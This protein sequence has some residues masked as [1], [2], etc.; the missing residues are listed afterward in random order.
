MQDACNACYNAASKLFPKAKVLMCYYHVMANIKKHKNKL[1]NEDD[2]KKY[3]AKYKDFMNDIMQI[4]YSTTEKEYKERLANFKNEW[5]DREPEMFKYVNEQWLQGFFNNWKIFRNDPGYANTNS[6]IESFN[7][8]FKRDYTKH[9]KCSIITICNKIFECIVEYSTSPENVFY[10]SPRFDPEVKEEAKLVD[11]K[12]FIKVG[13]NTK[14]II[15]RGE[16]SE[17]TVRLDDERCFKCCS[18]NCSSFI[19]WA[20]CKH[21]VAY[22][23]IQL[24]DLYG[25]RHR[26]PEN[27]VRKLK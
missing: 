6:N 19:K 13:K 21:V 12:C 3:K 17:Y 14:K 18:C 25:S 5:R 11:P 24:L 20:I 8:S 4:H 15:Y 9:F 23:N 10:S 1:T 27:F 2:D 22:S 16:T 26:Q 7:A